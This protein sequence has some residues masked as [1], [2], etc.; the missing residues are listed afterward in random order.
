[1]RNMSTAAKNM[2]LVP[3]NVQAHVYKRHGSDEF[4]STAGDVSHCNYDQTNCLLTDGTM[5][6]WDTNK[7]TTCEYTASMAHILKDTSLAMT[8]N[9]ALTLTLHELN[10]L[11]DCNNNP[12]TQS[13]QGL[14]VRFLTPI[15]NITTNSTIRADYTPNTVQKG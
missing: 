7:N 8:K 3:T 12:T 4:E 11:K 6:I 5:L 13:D 1:M 9:M 15:G 10:S 14:V 2:T